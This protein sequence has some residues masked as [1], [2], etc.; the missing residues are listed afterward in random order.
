MRSCLA[1]WCL[2]ALASGS[3]ARAAEAPPASPFEVVRTVPNPANGHRVAYLT[4][5]VGASL[6]L[7]SFPLAAEADRRYDHYLAEVDV[8]RIDERFRATQ[9]MDR[10]ASG[11]LLAGEALIASA[12]WMRFV[13]LPQLSRLAV[14]A[15][16]DR[17]AVSW[18]F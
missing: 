7:A 17:C 3:P 2:A 13:H 10:I 16:I 9:R 11:T 8:A 14:R 4:A 5:A 18:R 12:V 6:V 15:G 1:A